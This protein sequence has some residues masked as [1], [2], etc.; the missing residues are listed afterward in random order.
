[1]N[2]EDAARIANDFLIAHAG[3]NKCWTPPD[4]QAAMDED[5]DDDG[6]CTVFFGRAQVD[7]KD[8]TRVWLRFS[9]GLTPGDRRNTC[10]DPAQRRR[11]EENVAALQAAHPELAGTPVR[12]LLEGDGTF[13]PEWTLTL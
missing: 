4:V 11:A 2:V 12:A 1:M 3:A 10:N 9:C 6:L 13:G 5:E 7:P 8:P